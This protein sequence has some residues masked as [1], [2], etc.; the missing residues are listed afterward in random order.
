MIS[1]KSADYSVS[2]ITLKQ[3]SSPISGLYAL[4]HRGQE[5]SGIVSSDEKTLHAEIGMGLVADVF[6]ERRLAKL[7]GHM[8]IGHNRYSTT[9]SSLLRNA[10]PMVISYAG[11][12]LAIAHNG[13]LVNATEIRRDLEQQGAIFRSTTDTEVIVHLI[14]RS[15]ETKLA[16]QVMDALRKVQGAYSLLLMTEKEMIGVRDSFGFRPLAIGRLANETFIL[17]SE[18]CALD[19]IEAEYVRDVEPGEMVV[20]RDDGVE[21]FRPLSTNTPRLL[22]F[23]VYLLRSTGQ[24]HL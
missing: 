5:S 1:V 8:A 17:S 13:N 22:H 6:N 24:H 14:A 16:D 7:P 20:I 15:A 4:Q 12:S 10:Q 23:R 3:P 9:G 2:I 18:T 19:L 11:G 21:F